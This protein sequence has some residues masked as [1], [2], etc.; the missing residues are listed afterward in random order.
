MKNNSSSMNSFAVQAASNKN[1]NTEH[2]TQKTTTDRL[3]ETS[4]VKVAY[5]ITERS[6]EDV[7]CSQ[8]TEKSYAFVSIDEVNEMNT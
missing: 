4:E 2:H 5:H 6:D 3:V 1:L 7:S 8:G